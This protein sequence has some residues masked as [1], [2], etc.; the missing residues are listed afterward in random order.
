M[1][2]TLKTDFRD[3]YKALSE[4]EDVFKQRTIV[5]SSLRTSMK[6]MLQMSKLMAANTSGALAE[7]LKLQSFRKGK[8]LGRN[9]ARVVIRSRAGDKRAA[10]KALN[11][12]G[13]T[14]SR[15]RKGVH[16]AHLVEFGYTT[17]DGGRDVG[18]RPFL[19]PAFTA[20][21]LPMIQSFRSELGKKTKREMKRIANK[22]L[23]R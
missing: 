5:Q 15:L 7:S 22:R 1:E 2:I 20:G 13:I 21:A 18:A 9:V 10:N 4:I 8:R 12:Y 3:A 19:R 23:R 17:R 6:P 11:Y 16:H 14:P